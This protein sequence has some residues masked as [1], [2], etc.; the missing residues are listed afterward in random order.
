MIDFTAQRLAQFKID[1]PDY[2]FTTTLELEQNL[3]NIY[4]LSIKYKE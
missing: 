2:P 1:F 4:I 3:L